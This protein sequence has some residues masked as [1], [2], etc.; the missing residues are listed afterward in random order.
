[1]QPN[2]AAVP[3]GSVQHVG[4]Q[5][6]L[7]RQRSIAG[8]TPAV[9]GRPSSPLARRAAAGAAAGPGCAPPRCGRTVCAG[10][11]RW[12]LPGSWG[13]GRGAARSREQAGQVNEGGAGRGAA[14]RRAGAS[15]QP[16]RGGR[17]PAGKPS[18]VAA[19][20]LLTCTPASAPAASVGTWTARQWEGHT[21]LAGEP[22]QACACMQAQ[23]PRVRHPA[24]CQPSNNSERHTILH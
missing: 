23:R 3:T 4:K 24:H 20:A 13:C 18:R 5:C 15:M 11:P 14:W 17:T 19:A 9:A 2:T 10:R 7:R 16:G 8:S 21:R 6:S 1:M 22:T 12:W